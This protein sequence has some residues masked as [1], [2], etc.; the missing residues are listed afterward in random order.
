MGFSGLVAEI[1]L[2]RELLIV[3]SGNELTIGVILA[4]WL[5][6]EAAGCFFPGRLV[7]RARHKLEAFTLIA[8]LFSLS[9]PAAIYLTRTLKGLLGA[10]V[11]ESLGL[12]PIF[13]ASL[14]I[15]LPASLLHGAL[16]TFSC[17][18]YAICSGQEAAAA[19]RVYV[20]ETVGTILGG[21]ACTYF[22]VTHLNTFEAAVGLAALNFATGLVLL[23]PGWRAGWARQAMVVSLGLLLLLCGYLT[24]AGYVDA[25]HRASIRAQWR[26]LNVVYYANSPYGNICV[27]ANEGQY[28]F[29]E[30]GVA[31]IITPVPDLV[32]VEEFVHL[33]LLAH[34]APRAVLILSGGAGGVI[35]EVLKHPSVETVAYAELDPLL[36]SLLRRFPT[37]LTEAEL[38]DA[39]VRVAHV[40]GR[41]LLKQTPERFDVIFIGI[42]APSSLQAN[43]FFTAEF[44]ALARDRLNPGGILVLAA[45]GSLSLQ[46]EALRD[47]TS[48]IFH[49]L[50]SVFAQVRAIPGSDGNTFLASGSPEALA[51]DRAQILGRMQDRLVTASAIVPWHIENKLHPGWQDWFSRLIAGGSQ[52]INRDFRP[53]GLFYSL[54]YWNAVF[55]P[56]FGRLF[57]SFE[58]VSLGAVSLPLAGILL[59]H[60]LLRGRTRGRPIGIPF[61]V[62]ATGFAGMTYDLVVIFA[63]QAVYGYVFSW[64]GLLVAS[65]MVG[66]AAGATFTTALL[67]RLHD[68]RRFFL[69]IELALVGLSLALPAALL[70]V[71]ATAGGQHAAP[72][73]IALF[74]VISFACGLLVGS[75][76]PVA[77]QLYL[78]QGASLSGAAGLLYAADLL[79]GWLAGIVAAV[80]LLPVLGLVETC[81]AV[82]LLKL[83]SFVIMMTQPRTSSGRR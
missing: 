16:F 37:P 41:L 65:F 44:F 32:A 13:Y 76:F 74:L 70:A 50:R 48:A 55:A 30:D 72:V 9:V 62:A 81:I 59:L 79:G 51:L 33:P 17:R 28:I 63:F 24:L 45:P 57:R 40:D 69:R 60:F 43:R 4:N 10:S 52:K 47:L 35:N 21:I 31:S 42:A 46:N 11:G 5:I 34:P 1:L 71:H 75:Q 82:G 78:K 39:R 80:I 8:V 7:D 15:L 20:Y 61:A 27:V 3:F 2:L 56:G 6:L 83:T 77:N 49:T 22:L 14:L 54:S 38:D 66:A 23:A 68:D 25:L 29:F 26:N 19:G 64:I 67:S 73:S 12:L 58:R 53:L 36:I 18:I